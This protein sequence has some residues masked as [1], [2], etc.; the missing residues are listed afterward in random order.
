VET[1]LFGI[2]DGRMD[3]P[4]C[5]IDGLNEGS[6]VCATEGGTVGPAVENELGLIDDSKLNCVDDRV[7]GT[8]DRPLGA[9]DGKPVEGITVGS[10]VGHELG[11]I[12][13][14]TDGSDN[15]RLDGTDDCVSVG[16]KLEVSL[17]FRL[18]KVKGSTDGNDD[19]KDDGPLVATGEGP[20]LGPA[21]RN[22]LGK[23]DEIP[24][25]SLLGIKDGSDDDLLDGLRL[26][27]DGID[28]GVSLCFRLGNVDG[29]SDG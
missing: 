5:S 27:V 14:S 7:E 2:V 25:C 22:E 4:I 28:E 17:G 12:D 29:N 23:I 20:W 15:G 11:E 26:F 10:L 16:S 6:S 18:G 8:N 21:V 13:G 3:G 1:K 9:C 19:G 24:V